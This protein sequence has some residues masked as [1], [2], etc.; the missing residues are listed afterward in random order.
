MPEQGWA[1]RN[2]L[3]AN[4]NLT[5][6]ALARRHTIEPSVLS[7]LICLAKMAPEIQEHIRNMPLTARSEQINLRHLLPIIRNTDH[8]YQLKKFR[9]LLRLPNKF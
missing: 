8:P 5:R 1:L 4:P 3:S 2:K 6:A 9:K 7:R